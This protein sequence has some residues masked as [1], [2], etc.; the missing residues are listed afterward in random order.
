M[1]FYDH[2]AQRERNVFGKRI[3]TSFA[4]KVFDLATKGSTGD[5]KVLELGPGDGYIAEL[6]RSRGIEY[7]GIEGSQA[8]AHRL[9]SLGFNIIHSLVPPLPK[10]LAKR[11][12]CFAL[13]IIEHLHSMTEAELLVNQIG[14][15]LNPRGKF[16]I[17]T[18]DYLRWGKDFFGC[19]YTHSLPFTLRSLNQLLI[20]S[21]FKIDYAKISVANVFGVSAIPIYWM[22]KLTYVRLIDN[23]STGSLRSDSWYRG[24]LTFLPNLLVIASKS[25]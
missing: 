12:I 16:V 17:A 23:L 1:S 10:E 13:H 20:N 21:G 9:T 7:I 24:Y 18:P 2:Y 8:V 22:A 11:D 4:K 14:D 3:A 19:D 25:V 6:C 15:H 5:S